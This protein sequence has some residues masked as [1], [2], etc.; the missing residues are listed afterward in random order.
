MIDVGQNDSALFE[1]WPKELPETVT[2]TVYDA[3]R[4]TLQSG[5]CE[6]DWLSALVVSANAETVVIDTDLDLEI[7][8]KVL[9]TRAGRLQSQW[10]GEVA[11][12]DSA[13]KQIVFVETPPFELV[14]DDVVSVVRCSFTL[15][16]TAT[17]VRQVSCLVEWL[18]TTA[19]R[20]RKYQTSFQIVRVPFESPATVDLVNK[21]LADNF[22]NDSRFT[23]IEIQRIAE[24]AGDAIRAEIARTGRFVHLLWEQEHF[25]DAAFTAILLEL[26]KRGLRLNADNTQDYRKSLVYRFKEECADAV[27]QG[28]YDENDNGMMDET[29]KPGPRSIRIMR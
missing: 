1:I 22:P 9:V 11:T 23:E 7:G 27:S 8:D 24:K 13:E 16:A 17:T 14:A 26:E 29:E 4:N 5:S 18:V 28:V 3:Y 21:V 25:A 2:Y 10:L 12:Y 6:D 19:T 20:T 15:E